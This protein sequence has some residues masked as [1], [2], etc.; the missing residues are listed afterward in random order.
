[1]WKIKITYKDKSSCT[2]TG[3]HKEIPLELAVDYFNKYHCLPI[4]ILMTARKIL[5]C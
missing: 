4:I 1:M 3:N 2:L 5:I